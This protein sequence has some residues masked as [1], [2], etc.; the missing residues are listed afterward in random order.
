MTRQVVHL[1]EKKVH[2]GDCD[3]DRDVWVL[4]TGAS[5][6][7]TAG[8]VG[9]RHG[10]LRRWIARRDRGHRIGDAPSQENGAQGTH[11]SVLYS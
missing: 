3:E 10:A 6:H 7:M 11:R 1:N 5:N 2:P 8:H 4:D 9:A